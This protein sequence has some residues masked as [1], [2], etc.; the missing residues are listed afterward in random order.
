MSNL[1]DRFSPLTLVNILP[2][3]NITVTTQGAAFDVR[4]ATG[5]GQFLLMADAGGGASRTLDMIIEDSADGS[6]GWATFGVFPQ[7]VQPAAA[8]CLGLILN[9]DAARGFV[10]ANAV[11]A[12][13]TNWRIG[14]GLL[15]RY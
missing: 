7:Q 6:T 13:V 11:L 12:N 1:L 10:R 8:L 3:A 15:A 9:L 5:M 2:V 14:L 4:Q